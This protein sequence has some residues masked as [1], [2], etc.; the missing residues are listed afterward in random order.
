M[1]RAEVLRR[2]HRWLLLPDA[3]SSEELERARELSRGLKETS[4]TSTAM[5]Q[6]S[7]LSD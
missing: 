2:V 1:S 5:V 3:D 7:E 4:L 6:P